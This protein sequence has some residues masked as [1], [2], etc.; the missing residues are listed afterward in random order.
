VLLAATH[1][2]QLPDAVS[3][4]AFAALNALHMIPE[5]AKTTA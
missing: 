1:Q 5:H 2:Q 4:F 3:T